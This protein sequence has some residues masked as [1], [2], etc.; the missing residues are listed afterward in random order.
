MEGW[1]CPG[2]GQSGDN[3]NLWGGGLVVEVLGVARVQKC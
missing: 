2:T 1:L 3:G